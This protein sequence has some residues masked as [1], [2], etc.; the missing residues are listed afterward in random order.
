ML[1]SIGAGLPVKAAGSLKGLEKNS[2]FN[3]IIF[4]CSLL[5]GKKIMDS[6]KQELLNAYNKI[7][8]L[9]R[10]RLRALEYLN[11]LKADVKDHKV[12]VPSSLIEI[13]IDEMQLPVEHS[14]E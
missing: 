2:M 12:T 11:A 1:I 9:E 3:A 7:D 13:I 10:R 4:D 14:K 5:E 6:Y 8:Q